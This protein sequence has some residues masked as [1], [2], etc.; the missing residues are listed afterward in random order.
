LRGREGAEIEG[1]CSGTDGFTD[2]AFISVPHDGQNFVPASTGDLQ[3]WQFKVSVSNE[4]AVPQQQRNGFFEGE[5][6]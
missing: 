6:S 5:A 3:F 4:K 2:P 1:D